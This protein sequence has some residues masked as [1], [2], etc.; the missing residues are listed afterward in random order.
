MSTEN[1][2]AISSGLLPTQLEFQMFQTIAKAAKSSA[3]YGGDENKIF[4]I[5][6]AA[7]ELGIPP[8]MALN[9]GIWNIAGSTEISSRLM[10]AMI[11]RAGHKIIIAGDNLKCSVTGIRKDTGEEQTEIYTMAMAETARLSKKDNWIKHP[12]DMLFNRALS[13]LARRL[14]ADVIGTAYVE[15]EIRD[16]IDPDKLPPSSYEDVTMQKQSIEQ[17]KDINTPPRLDDDQVDDVGNVIEYI[18][19]SEAIELQKLCTGLSDEVKGNIKSL[20]QVT[21]ISQI[22]KEDL[23]KVTEMIKRLRVL[24]NL[25]EI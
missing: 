18:S 2:P 8:V 15:G 14:F 16:S 4:M 10:T 13:R 22:K 11:R 7:R 12:E 21:T 9:K 23:E 17:L 25:P 20:F 1:L 19:R 5:L 24:N 6:L 3:L